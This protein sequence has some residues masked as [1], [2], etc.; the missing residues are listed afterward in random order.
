MTLR[1]ALEDVSAEWGHPLIKQ[2]APIIERAARKAIQSGYS[3]GHNDALGRGPCDGSEDRGMAVFIAEMVGEEEEPTDAEL[4]A[5][6]GPFW[7]EFI[8]GETIF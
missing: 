8:G 6:Y 5:T 7:R 1:E 2:L 4:R 3:S